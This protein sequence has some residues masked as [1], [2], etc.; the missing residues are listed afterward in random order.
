METFFVFFPARLLFSY[1]IIRA[2]E[3]S[4][5]DLFES[6]SKFN[7]ETL[8]SLPQGLWFH[9][10]SFCPYPCLSTKLFHASFFCIELNL[11]TLVVFYVLVMRWCRCFFQS[12]LGYY[13]I[14]SVL[15]FINY[16]IVEWWYT[17]LIKR[18]TFVHYWVQYSYLCLQIVMI[19]N[20]C[21]TDH[22]ARCC[23]SYIQSLANSLIQMKTSDHRTKTP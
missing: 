2:S 20:Y 6:N 11:L 23:S 15:G 19:Y 7:K 17:F 16:K 3:Y 18:L 9:F 21:V 22:R 4:S 1:Q 10:Q 12:V 8:H 13:H 14:S 5:S